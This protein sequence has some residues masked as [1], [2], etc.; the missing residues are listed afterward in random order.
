MEEVQWII[1]KVFG[2]GICLYKGGAITIAHI[3]D[4]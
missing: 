1:L 2:G 3:V 4:M